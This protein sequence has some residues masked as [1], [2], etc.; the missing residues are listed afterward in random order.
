[1]NGGADGLAAKKARPPVFLCVSVCARARAAP[2]RVRVRPA[3]VTAAWSFSPCTNEPLLVAGPVERI[4]LVGVTLQARNF[5]RRL[6]KRPQRHSAL[7]HCR[8]EPS[9]CQKAPS[10]LQLRLEA[11][12]GHL[13]RGE[14]GLNRGGSGR[15]RGRRRNTRTGR[16]GGGNK[17]A[18]RPA[19]AEGASCLEQLPHALLASGKAA[20]ATAQR[21]SRRFAT[22]AGAAA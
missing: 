10:L 15:R 9:A 3:S 21:R 4:N 17:A 8:G 13:R 22:K 2:P 1:M 7:L 20:P 16:H 5:M 14:P 6:A 12:H 19:A 11:L 18:V